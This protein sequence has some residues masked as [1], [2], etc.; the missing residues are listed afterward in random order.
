VPVARV[1]ILLEAHLKSERGFV[2]ARWDPINEEV[3]EK[4]RSHVEVVRKP[5]RHRPNHLP[6]TNNSR[7]AA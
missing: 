1:P 5:K 2:T 4:R 6:K 3:I 7:L